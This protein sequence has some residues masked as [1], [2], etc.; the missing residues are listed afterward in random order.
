MSEDFDTQAF[1]YVSGT[2]RGAEREEFEQILAENSQARELVAFWEQRLMEFNEQTKE[3]P[4]N[5]SVWPAIEQKL[6][7]SPAEEKAPSWWSGWRYWGIP[8]AIGA[9]ILVIVLLVTPTSPVFSPAYVAVL[10]DESGA[11]TLTA[12]TADTGDTLI[13]QWERD[14]KMVPDEDLQIWAK[15]KRDGEIRPLVVL[16]Q[17]SDSRIE[18][19]E[20][21]WRLVK[22]AESLLLTIEEDG[23]SPI[24]EPSDRILAKGVCVRLK[25][26]SEKS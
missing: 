22:D 9:A 23:G 6:W 10:T 13:L 1:E 16:E 26:D 8:S 24:D 4:P 7:P 25:T 3:I 21:Q 12:L 11:A 2:L 19:D 20:A 17:A 15:S 18:I 5:H 14:Y